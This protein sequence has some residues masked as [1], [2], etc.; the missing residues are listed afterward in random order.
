LE[1]RIPLELNIE[2]LNSAA[3]LRPRTAEDG[4]PYANRLRSPVELA[5]DIRIAQDRLH[6]FAGFGERD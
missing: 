6:V 2:S 1:G 4:C 5:V 3:G